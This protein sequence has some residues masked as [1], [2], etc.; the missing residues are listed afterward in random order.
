[1]AN[2]YCAWAGRRLPTEA[3]WEKAA[4]GTNATTYPWGEWI[5][6]GNANY[7]TSCV[8]DTSPV[9]SYENGKSPYGVYDM[10]GNVWEWVNSLY[11]PY[12]YNSNDGN[13]SAFSSEEHV[14]RGGSWNASSNYVRTTYRNK[15]IP[16]N[17]SNGVGFRCASSP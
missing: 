3:E 15:A 7:N 2:A 8:G 13:E 1:M 6:C 4:H 14:L 12:P 5:D 17:T 9:K 16:I 11:K 10:A